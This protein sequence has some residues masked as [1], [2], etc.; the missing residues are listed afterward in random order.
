MSEEKEYLAWKKRG[1]QE[2]LGPEQRTKRPGKGLP[3]PPSL[4]GNLAVSRLALLSKLDH[5]DKIKLITE[6]LFKNC[7]TDNPF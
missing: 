6:S 4:G 1:G 2:R 3:C 5:Q 7:L